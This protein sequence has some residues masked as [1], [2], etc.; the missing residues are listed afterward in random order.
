MQKKEK[1]NVDMK[2]E[3]DQEIAAMKEEFRKQVDRG[4][5]KL[6]EQ[7]KVCCNI[8]IIQLVYVL[9]DVSTPCVRSIPARW[10]SSGVRWLLCKRISG[11]R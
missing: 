2:E 10:K 7:R 3:F 8:S 6:A 9:H 1:N 5:Q 11:R 4:E